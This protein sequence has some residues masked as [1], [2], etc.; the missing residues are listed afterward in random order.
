MPLAALPLAAL[1]PES[2][3]RDLPPSPPSRS[4]RPLPASPMSA[5]RPLPRRPRHRRPR[6]SSR[7]RARR[8]RP[9]PPR[10]GRPRHRGR[11]TG[12]PREARRNGPPR[13]VRRTGVPPPYRP[14]TLHLPPDLVR[15]SPGRPPEAAP[16]DPPRA[17]PRRAGRLAALTAAAPAVDRLLRLAA[18]VDRLSAP[19]P[20]APSRRHP[21]ALLDRPPAVRSRRP[22]VWVDVA[23]PPGLGHQPAPAVPEGAAAP[24]APEPADRVATEVRDLGLATAAGA[25]EGGWDAVPCRRLR[26]DEVVR[27]DVGGPRSADLV[28]A[29]A[30]WRSWSRPS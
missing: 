30:T 15:A 4:V 18:A 20:A 12:P 11:R 2:R 22:R 19:A 21:A 13:E 24:L 27:A 10:R 3:R 5:P 25:R 29:D 6:P 14:S 23:R 17:S 1:P 28:V 16:A 7:R 9:R 26:L 8:P